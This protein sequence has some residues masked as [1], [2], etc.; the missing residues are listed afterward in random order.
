MRRT[1][2]GPWLTGPWR[3]AAFVLLL[4]AIVMFGI[5][6]TQTGGR[7]HGWWM[8]GGTVALVLGIGLCVWRRR[9]Y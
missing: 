8:L 6:I 3:V 4:G 7:S 1:L 9:A 2:D 5:A